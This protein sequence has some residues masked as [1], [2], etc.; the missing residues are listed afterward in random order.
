VIAS[1]E[2]IR[3]ACPHTACQETISGITYCADCGVVLR[4]RRPRAGRGTV[5]RTVSADPDLVQ[6]RCLECGLDTVRRSC[7][8][9]GG[10]CPDCEAR[11]DSLDPVSAR[12]LDPWGG[13]RGG[14]EPGA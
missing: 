4:T 3:A 2:Q 9:A 10:R 6:F 8:V 13:R 12:G 1:L 11:Y 7:D 14:S 5:V